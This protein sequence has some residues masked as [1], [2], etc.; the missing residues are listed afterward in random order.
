MKIEA[1]GI[2]LG[3]RGRAM[4]MCFSTGSFLLFY[5]VT[6]C[7]GRGVGRREGREVVALT[8]RSASFKK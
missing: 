7:R 2:A 6:M 5:A 4:E 3:T 8:F 1:L